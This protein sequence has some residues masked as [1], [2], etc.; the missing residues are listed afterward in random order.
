MLGRQKGLGKWGFHTA[1]KW[2]VQYRQTLA[3]IYGPLRA[4]YV[5]RAW[6]KV[7]LPGPWPPAQNPTGTFLR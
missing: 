6:R 7:P 2:L 5:P 3:L 4:D 1:L